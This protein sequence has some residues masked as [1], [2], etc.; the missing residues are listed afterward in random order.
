MQIFAWCLVLSSQAG[1]GVSTD[2]ARPVILKF[3]CMLTSVNIFPDYEKMSNHMSFRLFIRFVIDVLDKF[4][5]Q[6]TLYFFKTGFQRDSP[7]SP[8]W[9]TNIDKALKGESA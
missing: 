2:Y 1:S 6:K 9:D 3:V 7:D 5:F 8:T 4:S